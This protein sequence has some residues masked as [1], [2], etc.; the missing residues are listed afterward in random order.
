MTSLLDSHT[1]TNNKLE[2]LSDVQT[3]NEIPHDKNDIRGIAYVHA[4]RKDN[5]CMQRQL[6]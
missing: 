2:M 4:Y 3:G 6:V 5:M 1:T